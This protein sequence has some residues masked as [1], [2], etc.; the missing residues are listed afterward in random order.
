METLRIAVC[1]SNMEERQRI[2]KIITDYYENNHIKI[3]IHSYSTGKAFLEKC[4]TIVYR[5][6]FMDINL[7]IE[8]GLDTIE[9]YRECTQKYGHVIFLSKSE[10]H[11][12]K[13]IDLNAFAY[14][15]KPVSPEKIKDILKKIPLSFLR[16]NE[17]SKR[18]SFKAIDGTA[19]I[20]YDDILYI[21][22]SSRKVLVVTTVKTFISCLPLKAFSQLLAEDFFS[23]PH[24][25]YIINL[26]FVLQTQKDFI[27]MSNNEKIRLSQ[28][29]RKTFLDTYETYINRQTNIITIY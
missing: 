22:C 6:I 15:L 2:V 4:K 27:I 1:Y 17:N 12:K 16:K 19:T 5:I 25:S 23:S 26:N 24:G 18:L 20:D 14:L 9:L 11:E 8:S 21:T 29:K 10:G 28:Q 3:L 13:A 7:D